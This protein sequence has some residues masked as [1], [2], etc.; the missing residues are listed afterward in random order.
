MSR[1]FDIA[2]DDCLN[3]LRTGTSVTDCLA[4]Y[5]EHAEELQPLL[6]LAS[7]V[8][9]VRTPRPDPIAVQANR[10]RM[11]YAAQAA[12]GRRQQRRL[13]PFVWLWGKPGRNRIRPLYQGIMTLAT[14]VVLV[15]LAVGILFAFA[16][17]SLP[18]EAL[19]RVKRFGENVRLSVTF[20]PTARQELRGE[21]MLE[22]QREVRQVL[23]AGQRAVL[24]FRGELEVIGDDYWIVGGLKVTLRN[25]KGGKPAVRT[26]TET[27]GKDKSDKK[28]TPEKPSGGTR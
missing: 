6:S 28:V 13:A 14:M 7:G 18:G 26:P 9:A 16:A 24:E 11:L 20:N 3:L 25:D 4:R 10:Q 22:R 8:R 5:P 27:P 15:G 19:Y 23:D 1:K 21:Y 12:T 17:D 2:L